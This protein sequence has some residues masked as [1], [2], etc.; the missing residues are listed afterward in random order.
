MPVNNKM[1]DKQQTEAS[2][3][4]HTAPA[5]LDAVDTVA[6]RAL[7][8]DLGV[9]VES[10]HRHGCGVIAFEGERLQ[11]LIVGCDV[12]FPVEHFRGVMRPDETDNATERAV[13]ATLAAHRSSLTVLV[14]AQDRVQAVPPEALLSVTWE[15]LD[16]LMKTTR[17]DL[18]FWADDDRLLTPKEAEAVVKAHDPARAPRKRTSA[19]DGAPMLDW[20]QFPRAEEEQE[21]AHFSDL[22][23]GRRVS[24]RARAWIDTGNRGSIP[25]DQGA[26]RDAM[27]GFLDLRDDDDEVRSLSDTAL[28][29]SSIFV[30]SATIGVFALPLGAAALTY[31][32]LSGG[33]FRHTAHMM[34][35]TGF[36]LALSAM[37]APLPGIGL[38]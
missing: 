11:L 38:I 24:A 14:T 27:R 4:F 8:D 20:S 16:H 1:R 3:F 34:A 18:V 12:A 31:N 33:D 25:M 29:R 15:A 9:K 13:L 37:G 21:T 7:L 36:G 6:L 2:L 5:P 32:A 17:P 28:G 26:L 10:V 35:L 19:R 23:L 30:M 22:E